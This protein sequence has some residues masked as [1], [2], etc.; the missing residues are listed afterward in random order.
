MAFMPAIVGV[1]PWPFFVTE[2][3]RVRHI[4][5]Y[6]YAISMLPMLRVCGALARGLG[7]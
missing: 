5:I 1:K 7:A 4:C 3:K 2:E 6:T